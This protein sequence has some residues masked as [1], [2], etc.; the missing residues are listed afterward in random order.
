MPFHRIL[1][2]SQV[3][4]DIGHHMLDSAALV[5]LILCTPDS[6]MA[7]IIILNWPFIF[8]THLH[9]W[10]SQVGAPDW[11]CSKCHSRGKK[12]STFSC[13]VQVL[14]S[15]WELGPCLPLVL[16]VSKIRK[17]LNSGQPEG[18]MFA[19]SVPPLSLRVKSLNLAFMAAMICLSNFPTYLF[20][21]S[22]S[23]SCH[24]AFLS[25]P[26]MCQ[27]HSGLRESLLPQLERPF[28]ALLEGLPSHF[29][30][31]AQTS[32]PQWK[33]PKG[34]STTYFLAL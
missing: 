14:A 8:E 30:V 10:K 27:T 1:V 13:L 28:P 19:V 15:I 20:P 26:W 16:W 12:N 5:H 9:D 23:C 32:P 2:G 17:A 24:L 33:L 11:P 34:A 18:Q 29:Q 4:V 7:T 31:S 22:L 6:T 21:L 25:V 3:P